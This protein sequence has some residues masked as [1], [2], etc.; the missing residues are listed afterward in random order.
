MPYLA[1]RDQIAAILKAYR[2]EDFDWSRIVVDLDRSEVFNDYGKT[3]LRVGDGIPAMG[4][5][6]RDYFIESISEPFT[7]DRGRQMIQLSLI[8]KARR[9]KKIDKP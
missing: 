6:P 3:I 1:L 9:S 2:E 4:V 8:E 7:D 5:L